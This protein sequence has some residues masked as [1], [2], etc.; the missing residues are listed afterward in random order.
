MTSLMF[1]F[2]DKPQGI[3]RASPVILVVVFRLGRGR[4]VQ[5]WCESSAS[6]RTISP[7]SLTYLFFMKAFI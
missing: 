1:K 6:I 4:S 7:L 2:S 5:S 3:H